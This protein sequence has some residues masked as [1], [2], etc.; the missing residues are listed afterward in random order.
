MPHATNAE[1]PLQIRKYLPRHAQDLF[2][3]AHNDA[4]QR[5]GHATE[6]CMFRIAWAAVKRSYVQRGC[7]IWVRRPGRP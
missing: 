1:F 7:G 6:A 5:Y 4:Y 3:A 2:R